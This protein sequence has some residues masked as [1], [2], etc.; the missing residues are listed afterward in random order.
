MTK[1]RFLAGSILLLGGFGLALASASAQ[2][3]GDADCPGGYYFDPA[4][5]VCV[6]IGYTYA[7]E[8]DPNYVY[9]PPFYDQ[10]Y[11]LGDPREHRRDRDGNRRDRRERDHSRP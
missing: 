9:A 1:A 5:R 3:L 2:A 10:F 11:F 8:Y 4:S 6:P 7:P